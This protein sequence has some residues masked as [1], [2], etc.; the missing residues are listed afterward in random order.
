[1]SDVVILSNSLGTTGDMWQ[2]QLPALE[3]RAR[4]I[5]YE[6]RGRTSVAELAVDVVELMDATGIE[7]ASFC[8]LSL[9][10]AVGMQLAATAPDRVDRLVLACTSTRF[11]PG[12]R[13]RAELVR[14]EGTAPVVEATLDRWFTPRFRDREPYRRMLLAAPPEDYALLCEAVGDWD[15]GDR[16]AEID[17]PTVV[18]AGAEDPIV[19]PEQAEALAAG[20][21]GARL[22]VL[23]GA[24][25]LANVEQPEAFNAALVEAL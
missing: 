8:G 25:H 2:P 16:L 9:G 6:H 21:P 22:V 18:L 3:S 13:E 12:Y 14:A 19:P 15:F 10:G 20:I 24:A 5:R 23:P 7:R 4:V 1:V 11:P 17:A